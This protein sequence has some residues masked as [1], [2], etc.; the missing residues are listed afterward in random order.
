MEANI[1]YYCL[2][3]LHKWPHEFLALDRYEKAVVVAAVEMKL[4]SDKREALR[5]KGKRKR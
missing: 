5:T 3:K 4:E 2:H 1:A